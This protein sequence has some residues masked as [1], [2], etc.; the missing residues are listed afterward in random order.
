[1][2][3]QLNDIE[4]VG[5]GPH[6]YIRSCPHEGLV[7]IER[8]ATQEEAN[9]AYQRNR[10]APCWRCGRVATDED[11]KR[12]AAILGGDP[13]LPPRPVT[14]VRTRIVASGEA[15]CLFSDGPEK[16]PPRERPGTWYEIGGDIRFIDRT[17]ATTRRRPL[18]REVDADRGLDLDAWLYCI[19]CRRFQQ[20]CQLRP[21][22]S[23][24]VELCAFCDA[25]GFDAAIFPWDWWAERG[26]PSKDQLRPGLEHQPR[27]ES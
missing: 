20:V 17:G 15:H 19:Y 13:S 24:A 9:A 25:G 12:A 21:D 11:R 26:W 18:L 2:N 1:M 5:E 23:G 27:L 22:G 4:E 8:Y 14:F 16:Q 3:T 10:D 6:A 7:R